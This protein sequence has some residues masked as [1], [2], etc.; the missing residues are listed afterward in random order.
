VDKTC[1]SKWYRCWIESIRKPLLFNPFLDIYDAK[2][3]FMGVLVY[4]NG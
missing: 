2:T 1:F 3:H 4:P